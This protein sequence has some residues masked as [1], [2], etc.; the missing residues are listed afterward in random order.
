MRASRIVALS[1]FSLAL[2][3]TAAWAEE[4]ASAASAA[5]PPAGP[6]KGVW[7]MPVVKIHG[8]RV[9]PQVSIQIIRVDPS[10]VLSELRKPADDRSS[11]AVERDPF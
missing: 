3:S 2:C 10:S 1:A 9:Q 11:A 4:T 6:V 7:T 8:R 5:T